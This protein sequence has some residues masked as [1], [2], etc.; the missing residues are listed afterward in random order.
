MSDD[1][2]GWLGF[3]VVVVIVL[4]SIFY[5]GK[6]WSDCNAAGGEYVRS[7]SGLYKCVKVVEV[8]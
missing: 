5:T 8:K 4:G 3:L 2:W 7:M 6:A 1:T